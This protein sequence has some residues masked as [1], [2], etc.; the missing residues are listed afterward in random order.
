MSSKNKISYTFLE[1]SV[2]D[3]EQIKQ[4]VHNKKSFQIYDCK[5]FTIMDSIS[6]RIEKIIESDN[7][8][9]R[10]YTENR[11]VALA[12]ALI[13]TGVTQ[14]FALGSAISIG[15]HNLVTYNPDYEIGHDVLHSNINVTYK[16]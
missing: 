6:G 1:S 13:P 4:L 9:C 14:I 10:V 8:S 12:G 11:S 16:K 7:L 5:S 15:I 2:L 3:Y